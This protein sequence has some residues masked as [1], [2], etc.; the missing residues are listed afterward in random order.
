[1][2]HERPVNRGMLPS[3]QEE[4]VNDWE[5]HKKMS[6]CLNCWF[7]ETLSGKDFRCRGEVGGSTLDGGQ[8]EGNCGKF[9]KF[10]ST[11]GRT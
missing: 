9:S 8:L 7:I 4:L 2:G 1:M 6:K 3:A 11:V 5:I 10:S